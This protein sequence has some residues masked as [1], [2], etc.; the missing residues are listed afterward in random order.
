MA[1][2]KERTRTNRWLWMAAAVALLILLLWFA[3][4][5]Y[6]GA[7]DDGPARTAAIPAAFP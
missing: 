7:R 4:R 2:G 3:V 5:V 1:A 6:R